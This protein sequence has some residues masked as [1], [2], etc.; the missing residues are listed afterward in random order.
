M[1]ISSYLIGRSVLGGI[2][3]WTLEGS[4]GSM[5]GGRSPDHCAL[6]EILEIS[7]LACLELLPRP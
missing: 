5:V 4:E 2:V 7:F 3:D 6:V 1:W